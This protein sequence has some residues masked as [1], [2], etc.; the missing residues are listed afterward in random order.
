MNT[1][2]MLDFLGKSAIEDDNNWSEEAWSNGYSA[3][4]EDA[5]DMFKALG[6]VPFEANEVVMQL[7]K[8]K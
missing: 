5:I 7:E 3:A 8:L 1:N 4:V 6:R 2:K